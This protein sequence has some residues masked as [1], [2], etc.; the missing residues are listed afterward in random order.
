MDSCDR[1][2]LTLAIA[3]VLMVTASAILQSVPYVNAQVPEG[4]YTVAEYF[5]DALSKITASGERT[6]IYRFA[7]Y[8][9]P[10]GVAID[11]AGNYIVTESDVGIVSRITPVLGPWCIRFNRAQSCMGLRLIPRGTTL[12]PN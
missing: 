10:Y 5:S 8:S 6:V 7:N 9:S 3:L 1:V 4:N 2:R 12:S 11:P